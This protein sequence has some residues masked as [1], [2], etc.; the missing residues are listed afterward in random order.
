MIIGF[1]D[2]NKLLYHYTKLATAKSYIL[3]DWT[4]KMS[5]FRGTND[6][7]ESKTWEFSLGTNE[8]R[9]LS[10]YSLSDLSKQLSDKIKDN[11]RVVCFCK[12]SGPLTGIHIHDISKRGFAKPR[13]WAQYGDNHKGICL[14]FDRVKLEEKVAE[15]CADAVR[16]YRGNVTYKNRHLLPDFGEGDY[17][18]NV[19]YVEKH[20]FETFWMTH[21]DQYR[22]RLLFEKMEDWKDENEFRFVAVFTK[23][24]EVFIEI[25]DCL[26]GAVF[27]DAVD[28]DESEEVIKILLP[29]NVMMQ[30]LQWK[31][32]SPWYDYPS[33]RYD[34]NA[35]AILARNGTNHPE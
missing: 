35:R 28:H 24:T 12:D 29:T 17:M 22:H 32:C 30:G 6:P 4:L 23:P 27:G 18:I 7:K 13:M 11:C 26:V 1:R 10:N 5:C 25:R 20:G 34:R 15:A 3:K 33:M 2:H 14:A 9:N 19:D 21:L 16:F 8:N 31:N